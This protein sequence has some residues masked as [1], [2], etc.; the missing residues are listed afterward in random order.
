VQG[1]LRTAEDVDPYDIAV[2]LCAILE[3]NKIQKWDTPKVFEEFLR[4]L[5]SKSPLKAGLGGSPI[6]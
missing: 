2:F 5:F 6:I 1:I 4:G 3:L